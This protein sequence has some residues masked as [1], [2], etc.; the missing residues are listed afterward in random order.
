[1]AGFKPTVEQQ[2]RIEEASRLRA[3]AREAGTP[4][5]SERFVD[6]CTSEMGLSSKTGAALRQTRTYAKVLS[7]VTKLISQDNWLYRL[8]HH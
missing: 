6:K 2:Q 5:Y 4:P 7:A 8:L 3:R 1:M